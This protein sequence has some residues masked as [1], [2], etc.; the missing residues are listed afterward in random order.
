MDN[1]LQRRCI[2]GMAVPMQMA[3]DSPNNIG[4]VAFYQAMK[5]V[6][7]SITETK[8]STQRERDKG[9]SRGEV[10]HCEKWFTD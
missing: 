5:G 3:K 8:R 1:H 6:G 4:M 9:K 7:T 2:T 10:I